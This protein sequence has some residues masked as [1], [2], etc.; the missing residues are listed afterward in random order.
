M[1]DPSPSSFDDPVLKA[2]LKRTVGTERAPAQLRTRIETLLPA[3]AAR[4]VPQT[5]ETRARNWRNHPLVGLAAAAMLIIG[6]GLIWYQ[7]SPPN[8]DNPYALPIAMAADMVDAH[9]RMLGQATVHSLD[10]PRDDLGRIQKTLKEKLGHPVLVASLGKDWE[11]A[12][13]RVAKVGATDASQV[14]LRKGNE[15]VSIFS[16]SGRAYYAGRDGAEYQQV[17]DGHPIAGFVQKGI[18]HCV[19]GSKG[20]KLDE[21]D[22]ASLRD[23]VRDQVTPADSSSRSPSCGT[24][25][26]A[27]L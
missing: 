7:L 1:T 25:A 14:V 24:S 10:V 21:A 19:V 13:A 16:V 8:D 20:S 2:A 6:I 15:T 9:D 23:A 18:V 3:K 4:P 26:L 27:R 22:L 11:V 12:G 5:R 17:E